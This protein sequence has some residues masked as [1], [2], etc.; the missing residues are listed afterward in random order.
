MFFSIFALFS[1]I[2]ALFAAAPG[3]P[4]VTLALILETVVSKEVNRVSK[5]STS[6]AL[7]APIPLVNINAAATIDAFLPLDLANSDVTT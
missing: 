1:S 6:A 5:L 3:V 2:C 4:A 7:T